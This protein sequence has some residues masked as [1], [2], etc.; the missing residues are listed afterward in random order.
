MNFRFT[1]WLPLVAAL[2]LSVGAFAQGVTTSSI[3]GRLVEDGTKEPLIGATIQ[4]THGPSGTVYGN[5]TDENGYFRLPGLR[6]GGPY[7]I[8]ASY[9]GFEDVLETG[10]YLQLGQAYNFSPRMAATAI[11]IEGVDVIASRSDIFN[12]EKTGAETTVTEEQIQALPTVSRSIG[13]FT[14]LTPQS[15][16][17]EGNDGLELSFGGI[18]NRYNA[19]YIDGAVNNDVFGLAGS[20]TNGGQTGVSPISV[21]A[22]ESF[23]I[24]IA[25]FDV[26]QGGFGGAAINAITRSGT[27]NTEASVYGFYRDE[28][29]IRDTLNG[30]GVAPFSAYTVGAR[31]GGAIIP[32]KLFYFVNY[33]RQDETTPLPFDREQYIGDSRGRIDE[34]VNFL[35]NEYG[36]DPGTFEQ[37]ERF[38]KS[39]KF[40]AKFDYNLNTNN[41]LALRLSYVGAENLEGVQSN[42]RNINF[43]NSSEFFDART[44]GAA[45]ELNSIISNSMSN[46]LTIGFT[47]QR[48]DRDP[49]GQPFP[50][51]AIEDGSGNFA[52]GSEQFSTANLL[53]QDILTI[54]NNFEIFKGAHT[55]TIG[56]NLELSSADNLFI[57]FN[58]G[59]Y[60]FDDLETFLTGGESSFFIRSYSLRDNVVGDESAATSSFS[61]GQFG[62]YGQ[63]RIQIS[64][65]F[66][67]TAGLRFDLPFYDNIPT[68][69]SLN[70]RLGEF[71]AAGYDLRGARS[72]DFIKPQLMVSPR[73]GFNYDIL[74][75]RTAQ[76]RGGVGLFTSRAPNVWVGGA[77]NNFGLNRGTQL[78]FGGLPFN[79]DINSQE[80]GNIDVNNP[81]PSGDI[82]LFAEDFKLPQFLKANVAVDKK[83]P[84]GFIGTVDVLFNKTIYNVAY[85]NINIDL[86]DRQ[87][88]AGPDNRGFFPNVGDEV[89]DDYGRVVLGYNTSEGYGY[90]L[91]ASLQRPFQNGIFAQLS[92]SYGDAYSIFDGTSSQNSSQWRG[93]NYISNRNQDQQLYR[94]DFAGGHRFIGVGSY[95]LEY[96]DIDGK[97][98]GTTFTLFSETA[99]NRPYSL[100]YRN[101]SRLTGR[102]DSRERALI[103][104][105]ADRSEINLIDKEFRDVLVSADEQYAALERFL[106]NDDYTSDRRGQY[107]ERNGN[108][109]PWSTIMDLRIAQD[110][111]L[112]GDHSLQITFDIFNFTNLLNG[113]WGKR[114][115]IGSQ[116]QLIN[117][118][119]FETDGDG[120]TLEPRVPQFSFDPNLLNE[121]GEIDPFLDDNGIQSSRWQGQI[122]LR[123]TF[124]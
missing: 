15:T 62:F 50:Y 28:N 76:V 52:F 94:S 42:E 30:A 61:N 18:N 55:I 27:N 10:I 97:P 81:T 83:L 23:Q 4:A 8:Q 75:D 37:N 98:F 114:Q 103:Y 24:N 99:Q 31:I 7:T 64:P 111:P 26:R 32:D 116:F 86:S 56:G 17:T 47:A 79:P 16:T 19:I 118:E 122:G 90:N 104:I 46:A 82:D 41:K 43:L 120:S 95:T 60:E 73:V 67:L 49:T 54:N 20:G 13:D 117:F 123:Y 2:L 71:E 88:L 92:Y 78:I 65:N 77:Y 105:P 22:I 113:E 74:G 108:F 106:A 1:S 84:G 45:L 5:T 3:F 53:N 38:L 59:S 69:E 33:E 9:V 34:L 85:E 91:T 93:L 44:Y 6:V 109:G 70:T 58:Y 107:A 124:K 102:E 101:G 96:G 25:P 115:F 14:R 110:I 39:D 121:D 29:F 11:A 57:P 68:N 21:D 72:G 48:D 100:I 63:D 12:G 112:S 35:Q 87:D 119:G 66:S 51:V 89:V 80:P 36:Y 40:T